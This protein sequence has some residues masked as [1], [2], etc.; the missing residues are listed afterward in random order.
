MSGDQAVA[1][2]RVAMQLGVTVFVEPV[3]DEPGEF[4]LGVES[5]DDFD[6]FEHYSAALTRVECRGARE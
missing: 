2:M 1:V 3:E 5:P 4:L 6:V